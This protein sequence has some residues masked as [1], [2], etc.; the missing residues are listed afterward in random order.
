MKIL[1]P[2]LT[3]LV[4]GIS[5]L[6]T[7]AIAASAGA[8]TEKTA[9][10]AQT[11]RIVLN[12]KTSDGGPLPDG[13][14]RLTSLAK[15]HG[16]RE[17]WI[18]NP[19]ELSVNQG[20][21]ELVLGAP[22]ELRIISSAFPR[23]TVIPRQV[24]IPPGVDPL[25]VELEARPAG[26][27]HV[28]L[29][30]PD[31]RALHGWKLMY[32]NHD[33]VRERRRARGQG[34]PSPSLLDRHTDEAGRFAVTSL[35][36]ATEFQLIAYQDSVMAPSP[37]VRLTADDPVRPLE[38]SIPEPELFSARLTAPDGSPVPDAQIQL[39]FRLRG[40]HVGS[41]GSP[42]NLNFGFSPAFSTRTDARG[43]F[44][45]SLNFDAPG[46][47]ELKVDS[48]KT[49]QPTLI[50]IN[51]DTPRDGQIFQLAPGHVLTGRLLDATTRQPVPGVELFAMPDL[52][53]SMGASPPENIALP[54]FAETKTD[55]EG[56]FRFSNFPPGHFRLT[57]AGGIAEPAVFTLPA[58]SDAPVEIF[59]KR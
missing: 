37:V 51:R 41:D 17:V 23:H 53:S 22:N 2:R 24:E 33:G 56:R 30:T 28:R 31:G 29:T 47:H 4:L 59:L 27:V 14:L 19:T 32:V 54:I 34:A 38:W 12:L 8:S 25:V 49:W 10:G 20:S 55:D 45:L 40:T 26:S 9:I 52:A 13:T 48:R 21:V 11:R 18:G 35:P 16:D 39:T 43:V 42:K 58:K 46:G 6:P 1:G 15:G 36:L 50:E 3:V 7:F 5:L 44:S 57:G